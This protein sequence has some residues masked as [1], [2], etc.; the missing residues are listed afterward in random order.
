MRA[1]VAEAPRSIALRERPEPPAPG[2][3][4][5]LLQPETV[6]ICGSDLHLYRADLGPSQERFPV[7]MGHEFSAVVATPDPA[8]DG[9]GSGER[10]VVWPV[11]PCGACRTCRQGR[12]NVCVNL[13]LIGVHFDGALQ[14]HL[15]VDT[16]QLI[17]VPTLTA[18]RA[19][20]VEPVSIAVHTVNR[21][22][23]AADETVVILGAGPIGVATA[24][25]ARDRGA[26][27][28]VVDPVQARRERLESLGFA[29]A[30]PGATTDAVAAHTSPEGPDVVVDTTGKAAVFPEAIALAGHG[31]RVVMV[32]LTGESAPVG[33]GPLPHK[34]LDVLGVSCCTRDEMA[35]AADLVARN[36]TAVD[37]LISHTVP[38]AAANDAMSLLEEHP[39][40]AFKVLIDLRE[41]AA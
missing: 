30:E 16:A 20:L 32:G 40:E 41:G 5:T 14:D 37:T 22:R 3:G 4:Q 6:G 1:A 25:A 12:P 21:G 28:L 29:T 10:V 7:V 38:L 13:R 19:A 8:G 11:H 34:E 36:T 26:A 24:I 33:P 35:A 15:L 2:P 39:E 27:V 9:P 23:V 18:E 31:G 17:A